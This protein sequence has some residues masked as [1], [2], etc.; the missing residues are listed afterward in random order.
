MTF[1]KFRTMQ[2]KRVRLSIRY[3]G[4]ERDATKVYSRIKQLVSLR[5]PD[6]VVE[7]RIRNVR[8]PKD[9]GVF[10][11]LVD[12][13]LVYSKPTER[14]GIFLSMRTLTQ[15]IVRARRLRRPGQTVYGDSD[16]VKACYAHQERQD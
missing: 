15:A 8:S 11:I 3:S 13:R 7:K 6:V 14:D 5:F 12:D 10:E 1:E 2:Q 16:S 9:T 4:G